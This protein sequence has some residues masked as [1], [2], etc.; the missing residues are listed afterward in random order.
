[1]RMNKRGA[2]MVLVLMLMAFVMIVVI[3]VVTVAGTSSGQ[4]SASLMQRQADL[5]AQS[6][7]DAVTARIQGTTNMIDPVAYAANQTK[8][9]GSN[10]QMGG[11]K[12]GIKLYNISKNQYKISVDAY[13]PND[14]GAHSYANR[15]VQGTVKQ[16]GPSF[17]VIGQSTGLPSVI[18]DSFAGNIQGDL[19]LN[20]TG[21]TLTLTTGATITG[22]IKIAGGLTIDSNQVNIGTLNSGNIVNVVQATNGVTVKSGTVN[23]NIT[24][25]SFVNITNTGSPTGSITAYTYAT[26]GWF[27]VNGSVNANSY[28]I[29]SATVNGDISSGND[30]GYVNLNGG[31]VQNVNSIGTVTIASSGDTKVSGNV[32]TNSAANIYGGTV[33]GNVYANGDVTVS[34]GSV[35]G[36][37][38]T[39]NGTVKISGGNIG[40][41]YT[42]KNV[43]ITGN[44]VI[45]S[46]HSGGTIIG[47]GGKIGDIYANGAVSITGGQVTGSI[48]TNDSVT[49]SSVAVGSIYAL[50]NVAV[51][52]GWPQ[53][54]VINLNGTYTNNVD[55]NYSVK[56]VN[57]G[58]SQTQIQTVQ[59]VQVQ[60]IQVPPLNSI[61]T[62]VTSTLSKMQDQINAQKVSMNNSVFAI[63]L[64][65]KTGLQNCYTYENG[66]FKI[67]QNCT[68]SIKPYSQAYLAAGSKIVLDATNQDLYITL[69]PNDG[70]NTFKLGDGICIL[71]RDTSGQHHKVYLFMGDDFSNYVNL[72]ISNNSG[73]IF[74]GNE[75]F[76]QS[77][78]NET[79][80]LYIVSTYLPTGSQPQQ[81]FDFSGNTTFSMYGYIYAPFALLNLSVASTCANNS[82]PAFCGAAVG[83]NI[84]FSTWYQYKYIDPSGGTS[85]P[86]GG[87]LSWLGTDCK[88]IGTYVGNN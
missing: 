66:C 42:N 63:D 20:D 38:S 7:L 76:Y 61:D 29:S 25:G 50:H 62:G 68:F 36:N 83:S 75:N 49:D 43:V 18:G 71:T 84:S 37:I 67:N 14:K 46:I 53:I 35:A 16:S 39:S 34:G 48:H 57:G 41:I 17:N 3:G 4:T 60:T 31:S 32:N 70:T 23:S 74:M 54:G 58:V 59:A 69:K 9:D 27:T 85:G 44:P 52:G 81:K 55:P 72:G 73:G 65:S 64:T 6:V 79:P 56:V 26:L 5:T 8:I 77:G 2:S 40:N 45:G 1:M 11:W 87:T 80:N 88:V 19:L 12:G 51:S 24:S 82:M 86:T 30:N 10:N 28:V 13:Y 47:S 21:K 33:N 15:I 78:T 22:D